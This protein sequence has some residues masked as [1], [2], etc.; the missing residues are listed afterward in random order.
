MTCNKIFDWPD[1]Y[2]N[3]LLVI[4]AFRI[5][6]A[7]IFSNANLLPATYFHQSSNICL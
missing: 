1:A 4:N 6:I 7:Q 5:K 3:L 2:R